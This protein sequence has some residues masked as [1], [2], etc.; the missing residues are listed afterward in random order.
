[1]ATHAGIYRPRYS[2]EDTDP[3][4]PSNQPV[5]SW[6]SIFCNLIWG[7]TVRTSSA[8]SPILC[9][10]RRR[11]AVSVAVISLTALALINSVVPKLYEAS[12]HIGSHSMARKESYGLFRDVARW[13]WDV[14][15]TK[16]REIRRKQSLN[17]DPN[18]YAVARDFYKNFVKE[19]FCPG[20]ELI[21]GERQAQTLSA[22]AA[23]GAGH[24][25]RQDGNSFWICNP[26]GIAGAH[27]A[28]PVKKKK[29]GILRKRK[30]IDRGCLIYTSTTAATLGFETALLHT[31]EGHGK[32]E[33][34]VFAPGGVP[35]GA[36]LV[37][38]EHVKFHPWGFRSS[39]A[40]LGNL[41]AQ[42]KTFQETVTTLGHDDRDIDLVVLDCLGCEWGVYRD[43][44]NAV[45][46]IET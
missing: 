10:N 38:P 4:N 15:K 40:A 2:Y 27:R 33:L 16:T 39:N 12:G 20:E 45:S 1:M 34:H 5:N 37:I 19:F 22:G 31:I 29:Q 9:A 41:G 42:F 30:A 28:R 35:Q 43:M 11:G 25:S 13:R 18:Q 8:V 36:A 21:G 46:E 24:I 14:L 32:C 17:V 26:R 7:A 23:S 6:P 3:L 44:L